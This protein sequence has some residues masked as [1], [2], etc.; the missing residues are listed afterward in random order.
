MV[1]VRVMMCEGDG[2]MSVMCEC[3]NAL[4]H[5]CSVAALCVADN[6]VVKQTPP[7]RMQSDI[8]G[9]SDVH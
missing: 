4:K 8:V 2:G 9:I 7:C 3:G 5:C 1:E 6:M